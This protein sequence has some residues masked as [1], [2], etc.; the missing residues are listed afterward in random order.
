MSIEQANQQAILLVQKAK[1]LQGIQEGSLQGSEA[2][3]RKCVLHKKS[4]ACTK[5]VKPGEVP[6]ERSE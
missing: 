6:R 3:H 4:Q 1:S 5:S 2:L